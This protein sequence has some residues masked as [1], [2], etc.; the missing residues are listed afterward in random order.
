MAAL[1]LPGDCDFGQ[2]TELL[3]GLSGLIQKVGWS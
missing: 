3:S 1:L 2:V